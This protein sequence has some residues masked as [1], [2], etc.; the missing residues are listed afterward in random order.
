MARHLLT[1]LLLAFKGPLCAN[2]QLGYS[3]R[4]TLTAERVRM[5][6]VAP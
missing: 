3:G 1:C 4:G 5:N 6:Y 2:A